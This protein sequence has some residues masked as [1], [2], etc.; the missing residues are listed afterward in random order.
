MKN[1]LLLLFAIECMVVALIVLALVLA[2]RIVIP[3]MWLLLSNI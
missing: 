1:K 3:P 2:H